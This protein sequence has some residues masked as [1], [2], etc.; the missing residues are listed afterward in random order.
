MQMEIKSIEWQSRVRCCCLS[1]SQLDLQRTRYTAADPQ[2]SQSA[3]SG[4]LVTRKYYWYSK[5]ARS[6][7][8]ALHGPG[9]LATS[10]A[11]SP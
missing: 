9:R 5:H 11:T 6:F 2:G 10:T 3:G 1:A 8:R 4:R 7:G